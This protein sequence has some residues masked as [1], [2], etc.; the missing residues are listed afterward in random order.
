MNFK[1]NELYPQKPILTIGNFELEIEILSL[2]HLVYIDET[3]GSVQQLLDKIKDEG[4]I[5]MDIMWYLVLDK[6]IFDF[7]KLSF[8]E[9][10]TSK[11]IIETAKKAY[12]CLNKT[13]ILSM[14]LIKNAKRYKEIQKIKKAQNDDQSSVTCYG[15]IYDKLAMR[16][17]YT[18][19]DFFNLTLRQVHILLEK[20]A[21]GLHKELEV[22]AALM[23][24]ELKPQVT[25][26]DFTEEEEEENNSDA[27]AAFERLKK[28]YEQKQQ[29]NK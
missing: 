7:K 21:S 23:G 28:E 29:E 10:F 22:Q 11:D 14:P 17:G 27:L 8:V 16:Y 5:L 2:K 20:S 1:Y 9:A 15:Q 24:R 19:E 3:Y 26:S 12:E 13:I 25:F 18:I 6:S 4:T